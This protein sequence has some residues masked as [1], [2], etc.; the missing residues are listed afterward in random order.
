MAQRYERLWREAFGGP[1]GDAEW[2][3][4]DT[5]SFPFSAI[6]WGV[7]AVTVV[8]T[9]AGLAC[10]ASSQKFKLRQASDFEAISRTSRANARRKTDEDIRGWS[11]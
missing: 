11:F 9:I 10:D 2:L 6:W 1:I 8:S 4:L 7:G 5:I 3:D